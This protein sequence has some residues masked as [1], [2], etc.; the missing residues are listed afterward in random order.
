[1]TSRRQSPA[2]QHPPAAPPEAGGAGGFRAPNLAHRSDDA[3]I[4]NLTVAGITYVLFFPLG[5]FSP[6]QS[7]TL[8]GVPT[9]LAV[10][11]MQVALA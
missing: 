9:K 8:S 4:D 7:T 5:G 3:L 1:L 6:M 10:T 11:P 2:R